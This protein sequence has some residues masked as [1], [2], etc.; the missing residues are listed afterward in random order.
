MCHVSG[1]T[2]KIYIYIY[3]K[4]V[5]L[6][7]GGSAINGAYPVKFQL[8]LIFLATMRSSRRIVVCLLVGPLVGLSDTFVKK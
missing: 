7:G 6:V 5:E 1:V 4:V 8:H 3:D 2:L